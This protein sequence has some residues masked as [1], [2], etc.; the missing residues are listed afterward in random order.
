MP[1]EEM[2][3]VERLRN[4]AWVTNPAGGDALLDTK[5]TLRDMRLAALLIEEHLR[6]IE[7]RRRETQ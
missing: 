7:S 2:T 6:Q 4:P 1:D 3:L 5:A